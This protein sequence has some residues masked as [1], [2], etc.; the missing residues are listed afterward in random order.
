MSAPSD[1]SGMPPWSSRP[2]A[3]VMAADPIQPASSRHADPDALA[4]FASE[5]ATD[6]VGISE[7]ARRATHRDPQGV[8][9]VAVH[10]IGAASAL[11]MDDG[12]GARGL[13]VIGLRVITAQLVERSARLSARCTA[14]E[15][16]C[17]MMAAALNALEIRL[18][19]VE[20][21]LAP[22]RWVIARRWAAV[23]GSLAF[24]VLLAAARLRDPSVLTWGA[25]Q[26]ESAV[27]AP[28]AL[29][30][31]VLPSTISTLPSVRSSIT[32]GSRPARHQPGDFERAERQDQAQGEFRRNPP[33]FPG[34]GEG[35]AVDS[36][37]NPRERAG[38]PVE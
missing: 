36:L 13:D 32:V 33:R 29:P 12:E 4:L 25:P 21:L 10:G 7:P 27:T 1:R 23:L 28:V 26:P 38:T 19:S 20:H 31:T 17:E 35:A 8:S 2:D 24:V 3:S 14:R 18:A 15:R 37:D 9:L 30:G 16:Q 11:Q 34:R 6:R 22:A 5:I